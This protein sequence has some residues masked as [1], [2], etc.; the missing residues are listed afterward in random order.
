MIIIITD[1]LNNYHRNYVVLFLFLILCYLNYYYINSCYIFRTI[2]KCFVK[3][4]MA[5]KFKVCAPYFQKLEE[6]AIIYNSQTR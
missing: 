1:V 3:H 4:K 5:A 6:K 2:M